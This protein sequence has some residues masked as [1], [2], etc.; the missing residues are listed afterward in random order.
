MKIS[1]NIIQFISRQTMV[2]LLITISLGLNAQT[3]LK[4]EQ[5]QPFPF[6]A[7]KPAGWIKE[8]MQ[9]DMK[10]FVGHLDSL[11]PALIY[12]P[13]YAEGRL[14]KHSKAKDLGNL[15][16]GDADGDEQYKWWNSETQSNWW[17][18]YIRNAFLLNDT[19]AIAKVNKYVTHILQTQDTDGYLGIYDSSLRYHFD[20]ENGELWSKTTL[21][22]GLLAY[23]ECTKD[24]TVLKALKRAVDN[25]IINYPINASEPFKVGEGFTGGVAHGLTFTDVL[26]KMYQITSEKKY[27]EY[28]LFLYLNYAKNFSSEKDAQL[29]SILDSS[30]QLKYHGVHTYEHL[31]PLLVA[32]FTSANKDL[33]KA[34]DIYIKRIKRAT[35]ITG[36][37]IGDEWIG[38]READETNVGYEYCSLL[39]LM[40]S[41]TLLLQKTGKSEYASAAENI[42]YN[43]AQGSRDP[44]NSCIAYLKTDNSFEMLGTKNGEKEE[45]R[46]QTRY[47][48]SPAHQDVAVCC[49]PNAG[50]I[51][52]YFIQSSWLKEG[53]E[54]IVAAMLAPTVLNTIIKNTKIRIE[55]QTDYPYDNSFKFIVHT[56]NNIAFTLKIKKPDWAISINTTEK[57]TI[58]NDYITIKKLFSKNEILTISFNTEVMVKETAHKEKYFQYGV[59][60]FAKPIGATEISGKKYKEG[61]ED[62]M[63]APVNKNQYEFISGSKPVY[64]DGTIKVS[65]KNSITRQPEEGLLIPFG[66]TILRQVT[67]K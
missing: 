59:L 18:G 50:R 48:Y 37:A 31:R 11:V 17:D 45:G 67:F 39:E 42:F 3:V 5:F 10:G 33:Q 55:E 52:P 47:K 65:L 15:K 36:G 27:R 21:Y 2:C 58:E 12:D 1:M 16:S 35:T 19:T 46:N 23:Y 44:N 9:K 30:Y 60:L 25:V 66:R 53:D 6:G 38:G 64:K 13:I 54:T 34:L 24:A 63:Y 49:N 57:Y 56:E 29:K 61:F 26:D 14:Q 8:Q 28:A 32:A 40:D 7:I 62:K 51:T 22:R 4:K 20:A 43:A 41:Y